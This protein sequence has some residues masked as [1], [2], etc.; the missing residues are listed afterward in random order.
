MLSIG[1]CLASENVVYVINNNAPNYSQGYGNYGGGVVCT[2]GRGI[3]ATGR[4]MLSTSRVT[5]SPPRW[6]RPTIRERRLS[7]GKESIPYYQ[8]QMYYNR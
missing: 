7:E 8:R 6:K 2:E 3:C 1:N 5:Y 4:Y